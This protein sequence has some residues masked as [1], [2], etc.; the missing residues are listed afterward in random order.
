MEE[1][2][3]DSRVSLGPS[4]RALCHEMHPAQNQSAP[5]WSDPLVAVI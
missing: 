2:G 1:R 4:A 3:K 5:F